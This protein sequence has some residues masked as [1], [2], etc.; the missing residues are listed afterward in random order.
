MSYQTGSAIL[1]FASIVVYAV[2]AFI[3]IRRAQLGKTPEHRK[4][5]I[6]T[7]AAQARRVEGPIF[8]TL[9]VIT[10][11]LFGSAV[12]LGTG[13]DPDRFF[14]SL[15]RG[16]LVVQGLFVLSY[17]WQVRETWLR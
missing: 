11:A 4:L 13:N 16:F 3:A 5:I 7:V 10:V 6:T 15:V 9:L 1:S 8:V 17:Y 14:L 2:L 12:S